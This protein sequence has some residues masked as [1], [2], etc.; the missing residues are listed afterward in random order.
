MTTYESL[1][2]SLPEGASARLCKIAAV[3]ADRTPA[4]FS[5]GIIPPGETRWYWEPLDART[6]PSARKEAP[7]A[8]D[9]LMS[10]A[11]SRQRACV[12]KELV[13]LNTLGVWL[14]YDGKTRLAEE[15]V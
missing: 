9:K 2:C 4:R 7:A 1:L 12:D 3:K 5:L 15:D 11:Y 13:K 14:K 10:E 8:L 6:W